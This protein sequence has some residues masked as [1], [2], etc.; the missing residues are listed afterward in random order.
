MTTLY[1]QIPYVKQPDSP[2]ERTCGAACLSM[3]YASLGLKVTPNEI[4]PNISKRNRFGSMASTT[5]LMAKDAISRGFEAIVIQ[6]SHP[7][8]ALKACRDHNLRV[9]LNHRLTTDSPA[10][11]YSVLA[12]LDRGE[13]I[14][15]DPLVGPDRR[16]TFAELL[17]VWRAGVPISETIGNV[18]IAVGPKTEDPGPASCSVCKVE[19]PAEIA[20]PQCK[21]PVSL[22]PFEALGC[23]AKHCAGR[24]WSYL[25]C[26]E[27]DCTWTFQATASEQDK[28]VA[29]EPGKAGAPAPVDPLDVDQ[30]YGEI[31][32]FLNQVLDIPGATDHPDIRN[33]VDYIFSQKE[34]LR[35]AVAE[36]A[37][38]RKSNLER[39]D[40]LSQA[41]HVNRTVQQNRAAEAT[42]QS[43]PLDGDGLG[44][45]LLR[46]LGFVR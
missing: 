6:A 1:P 15:H 45:A 36:S 31:S 8:L 17:D 41:A 18:L 27:C 7:L 9:V 38:H 23:I 22:K 33:Q 14:V 32:K 34:V 4:W 43:L 10:G 21:H 35:M 13:V 42:G 28:A 30:I 5:H 24:L 16:L 39:L 26:P 29:E 37:A 25:C 44:M 2:G 19:L 20:C 46:N 40:V 12:D 11:H 3:V